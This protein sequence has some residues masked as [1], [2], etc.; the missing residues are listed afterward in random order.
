MKEAREAFAKGDTVFT[1]HLGSRNLNW[2]V[3]IMEIE[4]VGW[5]MT[6]FEVVGKQNAAHAYVVFRR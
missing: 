3:H 2:A 6:H 5:R 1:A 4:D